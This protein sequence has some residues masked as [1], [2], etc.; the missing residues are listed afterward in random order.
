[1]SYVTSGEASRRLG[2]TLNTLRTWG[3]NGTISYI[4][5]PS[6]FSHRR[7]NVD[8][9]ISNK[10][11]SAEEKTIEEP[12]GYI[13][14]R[15]SS[16]KQE[17]DLQRQIDYVVQK[18]PDYIVVRDIG[19]GLNFKRKGFRKILDA[20]LRGMVKELVVAHRD[21]LCRFGFDLLEEIFLQASDAEITVLDKNETS[22]SAEL[23]ED[24]IAIITVFSARFHGLRKYRSVLSEEMSIGEEPKKERKGEFDNVQYF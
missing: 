17:G 3:N 14:C 24:I 7:Y 22:P 9:Y 12:K 8:E 2:V 19:S 21:R 18:Y 6:D 13:Y 16:K 23:A 15:V 20:A 4:R 11:K 10:E 5:G 1:M